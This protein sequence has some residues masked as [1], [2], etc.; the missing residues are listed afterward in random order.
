MVEMSYR[1]ISG[2]SLLFFL[3]GQFFLSDSVLDDGELFPC[4][5][6]EGGQTLGLIFCLVFGHG[7]DK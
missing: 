5:R 3:R 6:A 4:E 1:N 7:G 2:P